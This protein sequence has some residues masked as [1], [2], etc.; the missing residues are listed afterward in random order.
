LF[1]FL[2]TGWVFIRS[3]N[4]AMSPVYFGEWHH[5]FFWKVSSPL[6]QMSASHESNPSSIPQGYM[7]ICILGHVRGC[8]TCGGDTLLSVTTIHA[9]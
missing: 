4:C 7:D 5:R 3:D 2:V 8:N 6:I 1:L 9:S